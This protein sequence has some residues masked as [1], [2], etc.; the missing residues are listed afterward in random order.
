MNKNIQTPDFQLFYAKTNITEDIKS[1]LIGFSYTDHLA[2]QSDEL[3][4]TIEDSKGKW[5]RNWFP[6]QG[7]QLKLLIGYKGEPLV[8]LGKFEI[9]EIEYSHNKQSGSI[10]TLKALSTGTSKA[11][12]T[13]KP[14][15]YENTTLADIVK[16]IAKK[17]KL[18]HIGKVANIPI[19]RATQYQEKD[20]EFLTRLAHEYN[21]SFKIVDTNL[22][23]TTM[24]SLENRSTVATINFT[25]ITQIR[26]RDRIKEAV[27]QVEVIGFNSDNKQTIKA[28]KDIKNK[29][30]NNP[31]AKDSNAD[32][33]KIIARGES[34]E[35]TKARADAALAQ[36]TN[37]QQTG[38]LTIIGNPKLIAGNTFK[39]TN[40]GMFSGKYLI[41]SARHS[42]SR[43]AGYLTE[44]DIRMLE[45]IEDTSQNTSQNTTQNTTE[46][47]P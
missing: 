12:R 32:T 15:A 42:Y 35:Q 30:Q 29:R 43:G 13:L 9:D 38:S 6:T 45:F 22:V 7:D 14:K 11:S 34:T 2:D 28:E 1:N 47:K 37:Q 46:V 27:K 3:S 36:Q 17:L 8:N 31:Q 41:K 26:L 19:K 24:Q 39:L 21:H 16:N 25:E 18:N 44:L 10:V 5:I 4:L 20:V 40:M 33:L 23:F